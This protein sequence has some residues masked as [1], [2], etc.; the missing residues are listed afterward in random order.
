MA[1]IG[2]RGR[3]ALVG[4]LAGGGAL[5]LG[6]PR[7]PS[8]PIPARSRWRPTA[9]AV[10]RQPRRRQR[11][12]HRHRRA[13]R[14][15][16]PSRS[17]TS[18]AAS[19]SIRATTTPSSP[20][21]PATRS[22]C[23]GSSTRRRGNLEVEPGRRADH[24]RRALERG[25][26]A[27]RP[28]GLRRQQRPGHD[29]GDRR[30]GE[31]WAGD[32]R[33]RR[34]APGLQPRRRQAPFPAARPRGHRGQHQALHRAHASRSPRARRPAGR[35][36]GQDRRGLPARHRHQLDRSRRLPAGRADHARAPGRRLSVPRPS[37]CPPR[38]S[39]TSCRAS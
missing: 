38:P 4:A 35:R 6:T 2:S 13:T 37:S 14:S 15:S 31:R 30:A 22:P 7:M 29:H 17:A 11:H 27:R 5:P 32:P 21:P 9:A 39:R 24:R 34:P 20:T 18:R 8:P 19:R 26:V 33:P 25:G 3:V 12:H 16:R 28:A 1:S 10:G 23:C 36:R